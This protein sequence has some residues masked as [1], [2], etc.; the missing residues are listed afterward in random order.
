MIWTPSPEM[1]DRANVTRFMRRH[2]LRDYDELVRRSNSDTSW[3]WDAALQDLGVEWRK[4]Y[5]QVQDSSKGFPWTRWFLDGELNVAANCIDRHTGSGKALIWE[6]DD[7]S[8]RTW[9]RSEF[10]AEAY[11]VANALRDLGVKKGDAVGIYMP[12]VP[13]IVAAFFGILSIGAVVVPVFS[14]YGAPAL[15]ARLQDAEVKV[16]FTADGVSRRGKKTPLKPEADLAV[17]QCPSV[18]HVIVLRRL[19]IDVPMGPKDRW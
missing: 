11:R 17:A 4:P 8:V 3:F 5:T 15:A 16:L 1:V 18:R 9:T 2:S 13:E 10:A 19:G 6:G 14:A 7:G 12:M